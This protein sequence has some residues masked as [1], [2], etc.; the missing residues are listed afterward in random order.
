M[1]KK[2][3]AEEKRAPFYLSPQ[4]VLVPINQNLGGLYS[5][6]PQQ[7]QQTHQPPHHMSSPPQ[8]QVLPNNF[9]LS[10]ST[11]LDLSRVKLGSTGLP[12]PSSLA[13]N[14]PGS[15]G[16]SLVGNTAGISGLPTPGGSSVGTPPQPPY[17]AQLYPTSIL[18]FPF[19]PPTPSSFGLLSPWNMSNRSLSISSSIPTPGPAQG[20]EESHAPIDPS[21]MLQ[22]LTNTNSAGE[23]AAARSLMSST[24][25]T[26]ATTETRSSRNCTTN[27]VTPA[28]VAAPLTRSTASTTSSQQSVIMTAPGNW[29]ASSMGIP[30]PV[31]LYQNTQVQLKTLQ[32]YNN[33]ASIRSP[34]GLPPYSPSGHLYSPY[35]G[36]VSSCPSV[37]SSSGCSSSSENMDSHAMNGSSS[38]GFIL[39]E[40]HVGPH[41]RISEKVADGE[42]DG[43][44]NSGRNTPTE[45]EDSGTTVD[46]SGESLCTFIV[47]ALLPFPFMCL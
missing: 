31:T 34:L 4:P 37:S 17:S 42:S 30:S 22:C 15:A 3:L 45:M 18:K 10:P 2:R 23:N 19:S 24:T 8:P 6:L 16:S 14:S 40:Y 11:P 32:A 46:L 33:L 1:L 5:L 21:G 7:T 28:A 35:P 43:A 44:P 38:K 13:S 20:A 36:S 47:M 12:A 29:A 27:E 26:E 41:K 39:S 9:I 25:S